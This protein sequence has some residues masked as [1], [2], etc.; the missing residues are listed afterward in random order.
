MCVFVLPRAAWGASNTATTTMIYKKCLK[1][2]TTE[3]VYTTHCFQM[4]RLRDRHQ[5]HNL[6]LCN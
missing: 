5:W 4:L 2:R 6:P 1:H 3:I